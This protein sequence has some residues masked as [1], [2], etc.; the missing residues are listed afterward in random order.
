M[1][2]PGS[3]LQLS[4]TRREKLK[5]ALDTVRKKNGFDPKKHTAQL[6][7]ND[8]EL[9]VMPNEDGGFASNFTPTCLT[10]GA[11]GFVIAS[12]VLDC[13]NESHELVPGVDRAT[14]TPETW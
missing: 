9:S 7:M 8:C 12:N 6:P 11:N 13:V 3:S 4:H 10:D 1:I 14:E 2:I 5:E